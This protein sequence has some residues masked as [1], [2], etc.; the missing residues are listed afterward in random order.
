M[1]SPADSMYSQSRPTTLRPLP[2]LPPDR[3]LL[4]LL[5]L[6]PPPRRLLLLLPLLPRRHPPRRRP[7]LLPRLH[8][9]RGRRRWGSDGLDASVLLPIPLHTL[10]S[11]RF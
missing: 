9:R 6:R 1:P 2:L 4:L 10:G 3:R 8:H 5:P 11:S 7:L